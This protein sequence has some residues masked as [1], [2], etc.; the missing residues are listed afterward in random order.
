MTALLISLHTVTSTTPD[1]GD[2][3]LAATL[4]ERI[5]QRLTR[6][7]P[8]D[9]D[10]ITKILDDRAACDD[11]E[12]S[13][14]TAGERRGSSGLREA[15]IRLAQGGS[16]GSVPAVQPAWRGG[17]L[18]R[19]RERRRWHAR[20]GLGKSTSWIGPA[21]TRLGRTGVPRMATRR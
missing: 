14:G 13:P 10:R 4:Y 11:Q 19:R 20:R 12:T 6:L 7:S 8:D 17:G 16:G 9:G 2:H 1:G 15:F 5:E 3:E 18:P 21:R